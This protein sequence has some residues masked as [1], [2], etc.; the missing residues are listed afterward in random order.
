M[1]VGEVLMGLL[2]QPTFVVGS[3]QMPRRYPWTEL[4][5]GE[6]FFRPYSEE[7]LLYP[8]MQTQVKR[9]MK[10][11]SRKPTLCGLAFDVIRS[12]LGLYITRVE[13]KRI[14]T[15]PK[16]R[17]RRILRRDPVLFAAMQRQR[18]LALMAQG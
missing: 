15:P 9:R 14:N 5:I 11:L 13:K 3:A 18:M 16:P 10:T 12:P 1:R 4:L 17:P 6:S 2:Q 8:K 7:E